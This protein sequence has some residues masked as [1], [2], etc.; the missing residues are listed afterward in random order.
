M[1]SVSTYLIHKSP[2]PVAVIRKQKKKK[3]VRHEPLE[4]HSLT[5][6]ISEHVFFCWLSVNQ[7]FFCYFIGIKTG[8]L[9]VDELS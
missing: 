9:H 5:E 8:H 6:G 4:A 2:V 1:G 3:R 7:I